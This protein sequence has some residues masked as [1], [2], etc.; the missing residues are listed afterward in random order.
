[1]IAMALVCRPSLLIADEPTTALD[2]TIQA[3]ILE[4]LNRVGGRNR[5]DPVGREPGEHLPGE[6]VVRRERAVPATDL[7]EVG[8]VRGVRLAVD[9]CSQR[10]RQPALG[11]EVVVEAG[12]LAKADVSEGYPRV[13]NKTV[14]LVTSPLVARP[15]PNDGRG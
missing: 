14:V 3:Q 13:A 4:L 15:G 10:G 2:V 7:F 9:Q 1:M 12:A 5:V 6:A 11:L 8:I